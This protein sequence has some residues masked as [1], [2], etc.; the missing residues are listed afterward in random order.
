MQKTLAASVQRAQG[1]GTDTTWDPCSASEQIISSKW[2][3]CNSHSSQGKEG[4]WARNIVI[5]GEKG[6]AEGRTTDIKWLFLESWAGW[7]PSWHCYPGSSQSTSTQCLGLTCCID[8]VNKA[9]PIFVSCP[10]GGSIYHVMHTLGFLHCFKWLSEVERSVV[11]LPCT[12][13]QATV[14]NVFSGVFIVTYSVSY[15]GRIFCSISPCVLFLCQYHNVLITIALWYSSKSESVMPP[16]LF[17]FVRTA[18][19]MQGL[20]WFHMN[21]RI[22]FLFLFKKMPLEFV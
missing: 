3:K 22:V 17:S 19:A 2:E 6:D 15:T 18:L 1:R 9:M 4:Y 10:L 14:P 21:F 12:V 16:A 20:L 13:T 5:L 7:E 11:S 8:S